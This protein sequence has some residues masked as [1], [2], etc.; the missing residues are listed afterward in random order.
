M[1]GFEVGEVFEGFEV[2][3]VLQALVD[4]LYMLGFRR[5]LELWNFF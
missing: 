4:F 2:L 1:R 3:K 5:V